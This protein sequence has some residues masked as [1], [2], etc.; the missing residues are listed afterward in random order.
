VVRAR[1]TL[2]SEVPPAH[3]L[4]RQE[5]RRTPWSSLSRTDAYLLLRPGSNDGYSHPMHAR[6]PRFRAHAG[7]RSSLKE[8]FQRSPDCCDFRTLSILV[9]LREVDPGLGPFHCHNIVVKWQSVDS[10]MIADHNR[11]TWPPTFM[12]GIGELGSR[13]SFEFAE[14]LPVPAA[15]F[16]TERPPRPFCARASHDHRDK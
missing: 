8:E 1:A 11:I 15:S 12:C 5:D 13:Q 4:L 7:A 6:L 10:L 3:P 2:P 14:A 9:G 16:S